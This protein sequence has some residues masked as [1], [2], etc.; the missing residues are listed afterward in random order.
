M[1]LATS[2]A[3]TTCFWFPF[4]WGT[5]VGLNQNRHPTWKKHRAVRLSWYSNSAAG[6]LGRCRQRSAGAS[7]SLA[8]T[9]SFATPAAPFASQ[10]LAG[11]ISVGFG[12]EPNPFT[13]H[14]E[15]RAPVGQ[16]R[17]CPQS[18]RDI[19]SKTGGAL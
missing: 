18:L 5:V 13:R 6:A 12:N 16:R 2:F 4:H 8:G 7:K 10:W 19:L 11:L 9:R 15:R 3:E 17:L 14:H 1:S